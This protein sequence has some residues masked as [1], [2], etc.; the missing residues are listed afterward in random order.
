[1]SAACEILVLGR[2]L[3]PGSADLPFRWGEEE[4]Q[5]EERI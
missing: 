3:H 4:G 5:F 1:M 2:S